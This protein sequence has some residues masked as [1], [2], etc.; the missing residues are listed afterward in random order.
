[1]PA[2]I[3]FPFFLFLSFQQNKKIEIFS[4]LEY[5]FP[6]IFKLIKLLSEKCNE[7]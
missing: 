7:I 1:M 2:G 5:I 6:A 3:P 4:I